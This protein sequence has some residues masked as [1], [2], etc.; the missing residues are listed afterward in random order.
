L[1]QK[2]PNLSQQ[3][4]FTRATPSL[5]PTQKLSTGNKQNT[6]ISLR[7]GFGNDGEKTRSESALATNEKALFFRRTVLDSRRLLTVVVGDNFRH[8]AGI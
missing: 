6:E 8:A 5:C 4:N 2:H 3:T 1:N 7:Q